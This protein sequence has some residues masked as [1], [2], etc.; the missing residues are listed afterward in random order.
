MPLIPSLWLHVYLTHTM[1][2]NHRAYEFVS[3]SQCMFPC[4]FVAVSLP[5]IDTCD[6]WLYAQAQP[7]D[8][9]GQRRAV[10]LTAV[11]FCPQF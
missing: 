11:T 10:W 4:L 1:C 5:T 2:P 3:V 8:S 7:R 6:V 9:A